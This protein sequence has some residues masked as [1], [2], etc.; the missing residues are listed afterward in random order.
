MDRPD[1]KG[2]T[3]I[4]MV[5]VRKIKLEPALKLEDVVALAQPGTDPVH[6]VSIIP[7]GIGALAMD[8]QRIDAATGS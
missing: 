4:L 2:R 7:R 5:H 3:D 8:L 6:K 1:R